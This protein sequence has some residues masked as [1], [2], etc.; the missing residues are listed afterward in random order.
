MASF[1]V[2]TPPEGDASGD[3]TL[4]VRDSFSIVAFLLPFAWFLW[5]RLWLWALAFLAIA[6]GANVLSAQDGWF[7]VGLAVSVVSSFFAGLEARSIRIGR[8]DAAGWQQVAV[9]DAD[10]LVTAEQIYFAACAMPTT[11]TTRQMP[12]PDEPGA[13]SRRPYSQRAQARGDDAFGLFE[14]N[15][16]R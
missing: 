9:I 6:I 12:A 13:P 11:T 16:G 1:V 10:D 2:L 14:W 15:G 4:F 3:R 5:H 8:L 7:H